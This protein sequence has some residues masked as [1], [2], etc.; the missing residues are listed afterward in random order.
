MCP[1]AHLLFETSQRGVSQQHG[2]QPRLHYHMEKHVLYAA[3]LFT[4][5][6]MLYILWKKKII[7]TSIKKYEN[8]YI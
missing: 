3:L 1:T 4:S 5:I 2:P 7:S 8:V 6:Y